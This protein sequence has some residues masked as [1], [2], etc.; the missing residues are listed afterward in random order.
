MIFQNFH[1][2]RAEPSSRETE[3]YAPMKKR[4]GEAAARKRLRLPQTPML[5]VLIPP[6]GV[7]FGLGA[8]ES[9]EEDG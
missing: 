8:T 2:S 3:I 1:N 5:T 6:F 4:S 7:S 9:S